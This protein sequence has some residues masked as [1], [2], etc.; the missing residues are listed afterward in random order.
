MSLATYENLR[1]SIGKIEVMPASL[2]PNAVAMSCVSPST[3]SPSFSTNPPAGFGL[4][5]D[6]IGGPSQGILPEI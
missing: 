6:I 4:D 3:R 2:T 5:V 1:E